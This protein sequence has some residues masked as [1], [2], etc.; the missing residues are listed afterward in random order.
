MHFRPSYING[1][2][3]P[4]REFSWPVAAIRLWEGEDLLDPEISQISRLRPQF[5]EEWLEKAHLFSAP[6]AL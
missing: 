5:Q 1:L 4:Q 3:V 6:I 2:A